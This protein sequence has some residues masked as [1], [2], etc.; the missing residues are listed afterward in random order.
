[1]RLAMREDRAVSAWSLARL[2]LRHKLCRKKLIFLLLLL[3]LLL[4]LAADV[5]LTPRL[6]DSLFL[7]YL[8]THTVPFH[9]KRFLEKAERCLKVR[10]RI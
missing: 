3:L 10:K 5:P 7:P 8:H 4:S 2:G 9:V 6:F 1:M